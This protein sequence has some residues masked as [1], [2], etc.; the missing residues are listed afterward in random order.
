MQYLQYQNDLLQ[1][2]ELVY[3]DIM[4]YVT[5]CISI[6]LVLS[7]NLNSE[8]ADANDYLAY[9]TSVISVVI[10]VTLGWYNCY[11]FRFLHFALYG[12]A[13]LSIVMYH[14]KYNGWFVNVTFNI[15]CLYMIYLF[16]PI[17]NIVGPAILGC[18]ESATYILIYFALSD[19]RDEYYNSLTP[20]E[21]CVPNIFHYG[22][23][24]LIGIFFRLVS[25]ITVRSSFLDRHQY[26]MEEI[27]HKNARMQERQLLHSILPPQIAKPLQENIRK[28]IAIAGKHHSAVKEDVIMTFQ[29]HPDVS[30]LYADVVNYTHLTTTLTVQELVTVLHDLYARFDLA[31]QRFN[32]QRIKFLGDCYYC[33]AGMT[34]PDPDHAKS[35]V[36]LGHR[37]IAH[38]REVR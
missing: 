32:V 7:V 27:W 31:A 1:Y 28:R 9:V 4:L 17:P 14:Q 8:V 29:V 21:H 13:D 2:T 5:G 33:V 15:Y 34:K 36:E 38:I 6:S 35:C 10:L 25:D 23:F 18:A 20:L 30:I 26:V 24:N 3:Y 22:C 16:L 12:I 37:M 19:M 11:Y